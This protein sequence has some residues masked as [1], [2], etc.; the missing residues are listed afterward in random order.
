MKKLSIVFLLFFL[1][2]SCEQQ[3]ELTSLE[4][5]TKK[6]D[7]L[8]IKDKRFVFDNQE[9]FQSFMQS[10]TNKSEQE[11]ENWSKSNTVKS[12]LITGVSEEFEQFNFPTAFKAIINENG[13]YQIGNSIVWY[14]DGFKYFVNN[15]EELKS[16]KEN[17]SL[18]TKKAKVESKIV[19]KMP[20]LQR[21]V[22]GANTI[23]ARHQRE[24]FQNN[25]SGSKRKYVHELVTYTEYLGAYHPIFGNGYTIISYLYLNIKLE[26]KGNRRRSRWKPAGESRR[27]FYSLSGSSTISFDGLSQPTNSFNF[28][29]DLTRS[30]DRQL[31]LGGFST[32]FETKSPVWTVEV[33]GFI[34]HS[35]VGDVASNRWFHEGYPMW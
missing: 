17:P 11:L 12:L 19:G 2:S 15:E 35:V 34:D 5:A 23:D 28:S 29:E 4:I 32:G 14:N 24:F 9:H 18:S 31:S 13:E 16:I 27:V 26:Y 6:T 25:N 20:S 22:L 1:F 7:N 33:N 10:F 30:G 8:T 3:E 21:V